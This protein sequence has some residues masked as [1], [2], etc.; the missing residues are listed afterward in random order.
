MPGSRSSNTY[1]CT[2]THFCGGYKTGLSRATFY[3]HAPYRDTAQ[4]S[5]SSSFQDFLDKS[6]GESGQE[7]P[8]AQENTDNL[9]A[10]FPTQVL[11]GT[12][13]SESTVDPETVGTSLSN[14]VYY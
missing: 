3:R 10:E 4:P 6:A 1:T 7:E 5:F 9:G 12:Q 14:F 8:Q 13:N 2:C 11:G